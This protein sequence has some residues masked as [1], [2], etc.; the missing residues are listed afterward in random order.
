MNIPY[1]AQRDRWW[2]DGLGHPNTARL[3][4][5]PSMAGVFSG[6]LRGTGTYGGPVVPGGGTGTGALP[7]A[8]AAALG[9]Q[10]SQPPAAYITPTVQQARTRAALQEDGLEPDHV[11]AEMRRRAE[12]FAR[13]QLAKYKA[14]AAMIGGDFEGLFGGMSDDPREAYKNVSGAFAN[15]A[16]GQGVNDPRILLRQL[17]M[18]AGMGGGAPGGGMRGGGGG[19]PRMM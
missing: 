1:G 4:V 16:K 11:D 9:I 15:Y 14:I 13:Q 19:L 8:L 10:S 12:A 6:A 18:R 17:L 5:R 7:A 2:Q 3:P